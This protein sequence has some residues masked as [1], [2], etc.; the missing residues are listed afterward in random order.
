MSRARLKRAVRLRKR[1]LEEVTRARW[2]EKVGSRAFHS[3]CA[4]ARQLAAIPTLAFCDKYTVI[5]VLVVCK[6][7]LMTGAYAQA[8]RP[9]RIIVDIGNHP[10]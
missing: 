5:A 4:Q 8:A 9:E 7:K 2:L 10:L 3:C 1:W 6:D